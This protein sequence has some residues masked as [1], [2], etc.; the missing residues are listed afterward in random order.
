MSSYFTLGVEQGNISTAPTR[1]WGGGGGGGEVQLKLTRVVNLAVWAELSVPPVSKRKA[2]ETRLELQI[3]LTGLQ[4]HI[5]RHLWEQR[6]P[7]ILR[8]EIY[9]FLSRAR[10]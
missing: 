7:G 10:F 1:Y 4:H 5:G 6:P 3:R 9:H 2:L 8:A